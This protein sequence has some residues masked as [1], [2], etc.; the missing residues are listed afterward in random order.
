M[1][2]VHLCLSGAFNE[3]WGYQEN[4]LS[5]YHKLLGH[6]VTIITSNLIKNQNTSDKKIPPESYLLDNGVKIIRIPFQKLG[7]S[8]LSNKFKVYNNLYEKINIEKPDLIF[9]HGVQ[10]FSVNSVINY[11]EGNK[12]VNLVI[13][14]HGDF[15]NSAQNFFSKNI[16]HKIIW[17]RNIKKLEP[18]VD[19]FYG[20]LPA[21]VDFLLDIYKTPPSK[22]E[23]LLMGADDEKIEGKNISQIKK[24]IRNKYNISNKDFLIITG[25]KIGQHKKQTL[26][27]MKAVS[28]LNK[29]NIKLLIFGSVADELKDSFNRLTI[30]EN[31]KFIGWLQTDQ[32]Y[33]HF[34]ASDLGF[35]PGR[36][37]VLWEQAIATGLP[38]V[39]KYWEGTTHVD[40]GGNCKFI[41][42]DS[43]EEMY[44]IL[45]NLIDKKDIYNKMK[46]VTLKKGFNKF[47]YKRIAKK[48]IDFSSK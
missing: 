42:N 29:K 8:F 13:D 9:M 23:L 28:N 22:T 39:F 19:K 11:V 24:N 20:V 10:F 37:S 46:T 36:H 41:Y 1:K 7:I 17:K 35:F 14:N 40:L 18:Y 15:T 47:S 21:R 31:I 5:K 16:L 34:F 30:D 27:L 2:I 38:C 33:E 25:G 43:I 26:K 44:S 4:L 6:E 48:S 3:N 12:N 45:F 32:I